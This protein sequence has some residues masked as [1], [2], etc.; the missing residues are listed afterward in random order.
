MKKLFLTD[1]DNTL[2]YSYKHKTDSDICVEMSH[3]REQGFMSKA[4]FDALPFLSEYFDIVPVTTRSIEQFERISLPTDVIKKAIV[5]NGAIKYDT[6]TKSTIRT[7]KQDDHYVEELKSIHKLL[8]NDDR[9]RITRF[10]DDSYVYASFDS[11]EI[12]QEVASSIITSIPTVVSYRKLYYIPPYYTKQMAIK[13]LRDKYDYI[14]CAGDSELDVGMLNEADLAIVP[15]ELAPYIT[16][17]ILICPKHMR[18][19]DYATICLLNMTN[20]IVGD[21]NGQN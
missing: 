13:M 9:V 18:L 17:N 15:A 8:Q 11:D 20:A 12:A 6:T 5:A 19:S 2:I 7:I 21:K 1:L 14:V 4:V 16:T 10:V 3:N